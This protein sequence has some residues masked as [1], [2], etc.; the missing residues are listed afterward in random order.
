LHRDM[1]IGMADAVMAV[2]EAEPKTRV[3]TISPDDKG[4]ACRY[5]GYASGSGH[6][7]ERGT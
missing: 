1:R 5:C 3:C 6:G 2:A 7:K 4:E